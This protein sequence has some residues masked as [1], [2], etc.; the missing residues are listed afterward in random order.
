MIINFNA[1][2]IRQQATAYAL[3][4]IGTPYMWNGNGPYFDCSGYV[5]QI[6][7][8][9][10]KIKPNEDFKAEQLKSKFI[11]INQPS[12]GCLVFFY[13]TA[14]TKISHVEYCINDIL[15]IGAADGD[16]ETLSL[17]D[18][19]KD[20]AFIKIHPIKRERSIACFVDPFQG[21]E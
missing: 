4:F 20:G 1:L 11:Q 9:F 7:K 16:S 5:C 6:I 17:A 3:S 19:I 8:A 18:A 14:K 15:S 2:T 10:G 13:N 12:E 21:V